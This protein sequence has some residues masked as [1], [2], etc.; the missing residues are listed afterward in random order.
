V[1]RT[2][3]EGIEESTARVVVREMGTAMH[4]GPRETHCGRGRG[5]APTPQKSG[6]KGP[7]RAPRP[8]VHRAAQALR[9]AAK[10]VQR[11]TSAL[12]ACFRQMAARRG[13]AKAS[14]A[15]ADTRA[16]I[17]DARLK[18]GPVDVTPGLAAYETASRERMV[19]QR[20]RTA[21]ALGLV[22][23]ERG[24]VAPPA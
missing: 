10:P 1:E 11:S 2:A 3:L 6:G 14:T 12:G 21:A 13:R 24:A 20:K 18:H 23:G 8:G 4:R 9:C 22:L 15:T 19:R 5:W 7:S 17:I 16:H